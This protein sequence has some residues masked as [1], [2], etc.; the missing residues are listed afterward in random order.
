MN[1]NS[2]TTSTTALASHIL[3]NIEQLLSES[4]RHLRNA[5]L[6][7]LVFSLVIFLGRS[8]QGLNLTFQLVF[9]AST[10]VISIFL[11]I[12]IATNLLVRFY[13][14]A[15][16]EAL[17]LGSAFV[18][19]A[20]IDAYGIF[21]AYLR[22]DTASVQ[23]RIPRAWLVSQTLLAL[24]LL[25]SVGLDKWLPRLRESKKTIVAILA[26]VTAFSGM[27]GLAVILLG[28]PRVV[29]H[30]AVPRIW[31]LMLAIMFFAATIV[32]K[33]SRY[34]SRSAFDA[35]LVWIVAMRTASHLIACQSAQLLDAPAMV[36]ELLDT[37]SYVVLLG[38]T[39]VDNVKLFRQVHH[40]ATSDSVTGLANHR[41]F[42]EIFGNELERSERTGRPFSVLLMD[43]DGLKQIND[44]YGHVTGTRS[45]CRVAEV[46]R[47][48][49]RSIDTAA[50]YGGDEFA[51]L[52]PETREEAARE[53][54]LR[55]QKFL[56]SDLEK[57]PLSISIGVATCPQDETGIQRLLELADRELYAMKQRSKIHRSSLPSPSPP[58]GD[59]EARAT[60]NRIPNS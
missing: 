10:Q 36:A 23:L 56:A 51:L 17:L 52:L 24:V 5:L 33:H 38:A 32:L 21:D 45:L 46:L 37:G 14:T 50:R 9:W 8:L 13:G 55:I 53:V 20:C 34:R 4:K 29:P 57:P 25:A 43:L 41:G 35:S 54:A 47:L 16:R 60:H 1:E 27:T 28:E 30:T 58:V 26:I 22:F 11:S 7:A 31:D 6:A 44:R 12:T 19:S 15:D 42:L 18:V 48:Q 2:S 59:A 40:R 49:C 3:A 39:L